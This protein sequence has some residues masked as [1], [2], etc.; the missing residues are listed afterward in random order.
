M[1]HKLA[2]LFLLSIATNIHAQ[3]VISRHNIHIGDK[4]LER[5]QANQEDL[6]AEK[7]RRESE[8]E[9]RLLQAILNEGDSQSR[10]FQDSSSQALYTNAI[11][12]FIIQSQDDDTGLYRIEYKINEGNLNRYNS[13]IVIDSP[14][15]N[16]IQYRAIDRA[17]N[18]ESWRITRIF[19]DTTPPFLRWKL[20]GNHYQVGEKFFITPKTKL[21]LEA[22]DRESGLKGIYFQEDRSNWKPFPEDGYSP[23]GD[24]DREKRTVLIHARA[25]DHVNNRSE[26]VHLTLQVVYHVKEPRLHAGR[27]INQDGKN[28]CNLNSTF[29]FSKTES[30]LA[31]TIHYKTNRMDN[32]REYL[33][34][35]IRVD[36]DGVLGGDSESG[37]WAVEYKVVNSLEQES[38]VNR[39]SCRI[40]K[41]PPRTEILRKENQ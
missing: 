13:P 40:D 4:K 23:G 26:P 16:S 3:T 2:I 41:K 39:W 19:R 11:W 31:E 28:Y 1:K 30:S 24:R 12:K 37:E 9:A 35:D 6:Q 25:L 17:G 36:Q 38:K 27:F 5:N 18:H 29:S 32:W 14:G 21:K 20:Q 10:E 15:W 22:T 34:G 8:R 7:Q 33:T